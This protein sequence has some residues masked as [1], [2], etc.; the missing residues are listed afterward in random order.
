MA[1]FGA[2]KA[3]DNP[4]AAA[5]G[6]AQDIMRYMHDFNARALS[7]GEV[8]IEIGVGLHAGDAVVGNVGSS[9]RHDYTA[10]G[11]VINVASR[12]EGVTKD[13]GY[14]LVYSNV[15]ADALPA[16]TPHV[17]LGLQQIKGHTPVKAY[18]YEKISK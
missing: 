16:S 14:R 4:S 1:V 7:A 15:V 8:P 2:P 3:L 9:S 17:D 10:I 5:F 13:V 6:A 12:L 11:D 18:G